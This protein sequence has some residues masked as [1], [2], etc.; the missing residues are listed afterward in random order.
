MAPVELEG[1]ALGVEE[2]EGEVLEKRRERPGGARVKSGV[3]KRSARSGVSFE[4]W[5]EGG[6]LKGVSVHAFPIPPC[7]RLGFRGRFLPC[8]FV[9]AF[10]RL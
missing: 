3:L 1:V 4:A 6:P 2:G 9:E 7:M 10:Y 5:A 8:L